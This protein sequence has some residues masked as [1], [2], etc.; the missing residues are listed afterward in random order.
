[1]SNSPSILILDIETAPIESYTWGLFDQNVAVKQIKSEWSIISYAAKWFNQSKV[2]YRDT[3]GRGSR[4]IRDDKALLGDI[5]KL[6]NE[7]DIVVAQN[8]NSFD[9]KKINARLLM[10]G[11]APYSPIRIIDTLLVARRHFSFTS[12][13]LEWL[14][15]NLTDHPKDQHKNF[16]G[17]ELWTECLADNPKAWREMKKYNIGDVFATEKLYKRLRPWIAQHPNLG[18]YKT[19][20]MI[21]CPKCGSEEITKQGI[22]TTQQ[23]AYQQYKCGGCGGWS[24]GK[25]MLLSKDK[26]KSM[27]VSL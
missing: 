26:R 8:G 21:S 4:Y 14:S 5:W 3:S 16:P 17:F 19:G 10:H 9:V 25:V 11:F 18:A 1:M 13:K 7:A 23:G 20:E 2:D 15:A 27:L 22:R 24:R 12:N 6:L